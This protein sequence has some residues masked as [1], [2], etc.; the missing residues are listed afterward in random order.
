M[1]EDFQDQE[2]LKLSDVDEKKI[3]KL[4]EDK[5]FKLDCTIESNNLK[6]SLKEVNSYSP[7]YYEIYYTKDELDKNKE[8]FK[9]FKTLE[10]IQSNLIKLFS[11]K[12][13]T[14]ESIDDD[15]KIKLHIE[16]SVLADDVEMDFILDRKTVENKD[17]SLY[18]LYKIQKENYNIIEKIKAICKQDNDKNENIAKEI[19]A[20]LSEKFDNYYN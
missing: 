19:L 13:T 6:L 3:K 2:I 14:L 8:F 5:I 4:G 1:V 9:A 16:S 17:E 12:T 7:Y 10:E 15:S 18:F 20:K 11:K